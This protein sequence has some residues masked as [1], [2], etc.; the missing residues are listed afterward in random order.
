MKAQTHGAGE[1][2]AKL[3]GAAWVWILPRESTQQGRQNIDLAIQTQGVNSAGKK[4]IDRAIQE[5][6]Y[7]NLFGVQKEKQ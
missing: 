7:Y 4:E 1:I 2:N 3:V 5:A 6:S